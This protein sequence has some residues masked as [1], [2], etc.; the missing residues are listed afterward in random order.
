MV[1]K[2][3]SGRNTQPYIVTEALSGVE[4]TSQVKKQTEVMYLDVVMVLDSIWS[5]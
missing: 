4:Q 2:A 5:L 1:G 3:A